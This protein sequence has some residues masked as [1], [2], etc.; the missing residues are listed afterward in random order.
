MRLTALR[1]QGF[2]SF[3]DR[4]SIEFAASV[5]AI[6]GPN[7]SGKS[8]VIDALRW[9][10]GGG[11]AREFRADGKGDLI[12]HGA[13]GKRALGY[14]E[15]E[16]E[17]AGDAGG[18]KI[19][20]NLFR[21]GETKLKL[22]GKAARFLDVEEVLSGSGLGRGGLALIGQGEVSQVLMADPEKLLG[23]VAEAAGVAKL[24]SRRD[25]TETRLS[26]TRD[27]L[28]R[29]SDV[30]AEMERQLGRLAEE[31]SQ[32]TRAASLS[33]EVFTLK[34]SLSRARVD[35]LKR[36][37]EGLRARRDELAARLEKGRVTLA[38]TQK[39]WRELRERLSAAESRYRERLAEYQSRKGD[40]RVAEERLNAA[41]QHL[42][43]LQR[44]AGSLS[45]EVE[46]LAGTEP[47][48]PPDGD[49]AALQ[50]RVDE[51]AAA[52]DESRARVQ[53]AEQRLAE[54]RDGLE[55]HRRAR[56]AL[57]AA[58]QRYRSELESFTSERDD[59]ETRLSEL[60]QDDQEALEQL[61]RHCRELRQRH[62]ESRGAVAAARQRLEQA[63]TAEAQALAEARSLASAAARLGRALEGRQ[64]YAKGPQLALTSGLSG[65]VGSVADVIKVEERYSAAVAAALGRRLEHV[66]V[67]TAEV[68]RSVLAHVRREGGWVT[69][70]PLDLIE[71][72]EARLPQELLAAAG[73]IGPLVDVVEVETRFVPMVRQLLGNVVLA[74]SMDVAVAL[75]RRFKRRPRLVTLE[76]DVLESF[77]AMSGGRRPGGAD[78]LGFTAEVEAA[79]TAAEE[80]RAAAV[81]AQ[82]EASARLREL[83]DA[84]RDQEDAERRLGELEA[85]RSERRRQQLAAATLRSE[86]EAR[87]LALSERLQALAVPPDPGE[88][89]DQTPEL[90]ADAAN[91][92]GVLSAARQELEDLQQQL[93]E[94]ERALL[95]QNERNK[96]YERS[97]DA[98]RDGQRRLGDLRRR[99]DEQRALLEDA[100]ARVRAAEEAVGAAEKALP[101]DLNMLEAEYR[102]LTGECTAAEQ[103]LDQ[104]TRAQAQGGARL[105][106]LQLTLARRETALEGAESELAGF[107]E[108]VALVEGSARTLR[109]RLAACEGELEEVGP[110]NHRAGEDHEA[111]LG[112]HQELTS[113]I[114]DTEEAIA[115]L[116]QVLS[117]LD[118]DTNERLSNAAETLEQGFASYVAELFGSQARAEVE[119]LRDGGRPT[120]LSISLTPPGKETKSL[121][122]LSVGERTM[123]ALAFLF[124]LIGNVTS[125]DAGISIAILDEVD[126]P[127]DEANIRRFTSFLTRLA[128][129]GTQFVLITHQKATMEVA[130]ALW[131]VTS[132]QGV[133]RVFSI[134]R[135]EHVALG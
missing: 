59:V 87:R 124:A 63:R 38:A 2:K 116:E 94:A 61:E 10:T 13:S 120:G 119:L 35:A 44:E 90:E 14:A 28:L 66:V 115:E 26:A 42:E 17:L 84:E 21:D 48:T 43:S 3:G 117:E 49:P 36:E 123:G 56:E 6:V 67:E 57:E 33:R 31:A 75:A 127:L 95:V 54:A 80:A 105:E 70:L 47:P 85:E 129:A 133:S 64:G 22:N 20:R 8:N 4:T 69:A 51:L 30:A 112:R 55:R 96:A 102:R 25:Q 103:S 65:I 113:Q 134:S 125:R 46:R 53:E 92:A 72:R 34:F 93:T 68:G 41:M 12:F 45:E 110:V 99:Q 27:H 58:W 130:D 79:N 91:L 121:A 109:E 114:R 77:G 126:A 23:Y 32:A 111:L 52:R 5:T 88:R 74:E 86:L 16:V 82:A 97:L 71:E 83:E 15:V 37:V 118:R 107:P 50:R 19:L 131:G 62:A 100:R 1:L 7:G 89:P 60:P 9:A 24:S 81:A 40:V 108:G 135:P 106:E 29:L 39:E 78:L 104:A 11:R 98:F 18:F 76:G 132:D 122:L 128:G 73:V 101:D